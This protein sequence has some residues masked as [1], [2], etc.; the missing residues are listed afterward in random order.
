MDIFRSFHLV[1]LI[2]KGGLRERA[3]RSRKYSGSENNVKTLDDHGYSPSTQNK[4]EKKNL[5]DNPTN[6]STENTKSN[7][8]H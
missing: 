3:N 1:Q 2:K 4:N 8:E 5:E 7:P 6:L